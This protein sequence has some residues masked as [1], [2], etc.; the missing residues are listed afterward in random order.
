MSD[1]WYVL[2][3]PCLSCM[4]PAQLINMFRE[5]LQLQAQAGCAS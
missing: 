2:L 3:L 1:C 4:F 5:L